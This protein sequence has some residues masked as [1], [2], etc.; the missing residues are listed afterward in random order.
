[1][2]HTGFNICKAL[3]ATEKCFRVQQYENGEFKDLFHEHI[4]KSRISAENS[5]QFL[6]AIII[7]NHPFGS[8]EILKTYLNTR[9]KNPV[10]IKLCNSHIEYPEPGVMR[11]YLC[12]EGI[13]TW[14]D[15]VISLEHFRR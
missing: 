15:E 7:K 11:K 2:T 1:M 3:K 4:S 12:A 14:Y 10:R 8:S 6:R 5:F 9:G 13:N